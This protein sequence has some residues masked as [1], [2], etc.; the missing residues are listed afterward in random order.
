MTP[1]ACWDVLKAT[2]QARP[3]H[4]DQYLL[5]DAAWEMYRMEKNTVL[6]Q[7][8]LEL[9]CWSSLPECKA[10]LWYEVE[11]W[12][13]YASRVFAFHRRKWDGLQMGCC[14]MRWS[15]F[16]HNFERSFWEA[17]DEDWTKVFP[18]TYAMCMRVQE[19]SLRNTKLVQFAR[20][21]EAASTEWRKLY[22]EFYESW[23]LFL[24]FFQPQYR[25]SAA[26]GLAA[27]VGLPCPD[28]AGAQDIFFMKIFLKDVKTVKMYYQQF[29]WDAYSGEIISMASCMQQTSREDF[30]T[31]YPQLHEFGTAVFRPLTTH[32]LACELGF[33]WS[34]GS[35]RDNQTDQRHDEQNAVML[36]RVRHFSEA[37]RRSDCDYRCS[38]NASVAQLQLAA[39][40]LIAEQH[41]YTPAKMHEAQTPSSKAFQRNTKLRV[42]AIDEQRAKTSTCIGSQWADSHGRNELTHEEKSSFIEKHRIIPFDAVLQKELLQHPQVVAFQQSLHEVYSFAKLRKFKARDL[43]H[44]VSTFLPRYTID[45]FMLQDPT[46]NLYGS[47]GTPTKTKLCNGAGTHKLKCYIEVLVLVRECAWCAFMCMYVYICMCL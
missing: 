27:V 7:C 14:M 15:T 23:K 2:E 21:T 6:R 29:G 1:A 24:W 44:K 28:P 12:R 39:K 19:L 41:R 36:N 33:S 18:H 38:D 11:L 35:R 37:R 3:G 42:R 31:T 8:Y 17:A 20:A 30:P 45:S 13:N 46:R 9:A 43:F 34:K 40:G 32:D 25:T 47:K 16:V 4:P 26:K 5:P 22:Q 10:G